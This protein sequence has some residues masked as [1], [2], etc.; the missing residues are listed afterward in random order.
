MDEPQ[1]GFA[2]PS[3]VGA[4]LR[5]R[6]LL[7]MALLL[8]LPCG[9]QN[10]TNGGQGSSHPFH[11]SDLNQMVNDG[12][13]DPLLEERRV[14]MMIVSQHKSMV[15]D[16]DK[17]LKLVTELNAEIKSTNPSSL[18]TEQL[19]KVAEIEKLARNVKDRMRMSAQ[20]VPVFQDPMPLS[21]P[22]NLH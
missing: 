13:A 18:T 16:T 20:G 3:A 15:A 12:P 1:S 7:W 11:A 9:G 14:R 21:L 2:R 10:S 19:H 22:P 5:V 8:A 4:R 6:P 17:L